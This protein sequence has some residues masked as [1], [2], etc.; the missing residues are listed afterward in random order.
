MQSSAFTLLALGPPLQLQLTPSPLGYFTLPCW[1]PVT[2][3]G[4]NAISL[5]L[6]PHEC[7]CRPAHLT[8]GKQGENMP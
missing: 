8:S 3:L 5:L 4:Y 7:T 6:E 1:S 2:L